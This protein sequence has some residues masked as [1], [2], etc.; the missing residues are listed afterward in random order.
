MATARQQARKKKEKKKTI[1]PT[2][3]L[4]EGKRTLANIYRYEN[5]WTLDGYVCVCA[6]SLR[7]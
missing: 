1:K 2:N 5:I 4:R 3:C 6:A 7:T